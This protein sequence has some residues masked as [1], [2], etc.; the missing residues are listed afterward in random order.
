MHLIQIKNIL[1]N[2]NIDHLIK[3][4]RIY[5]YFNF[6]NVSKNIAGIKKFDVTNYTDHGLF[7]AIKHGIIIL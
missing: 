5:A 1:N 4:G 3:E 2:N 7:Q 6:L